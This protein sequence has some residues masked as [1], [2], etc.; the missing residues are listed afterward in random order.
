MKDAWTKFLCWF[1]GWDYKLLSECSAASTRTLR[2]YAD[3][4]LLIMAIWFYIGFSM[5]NR[6]FKIDN[7]CFNILVAFVF[8]LVVWIIERQIILIPGKHWGIMII[9]TLLAVI[10]AGLGATIIDQ[11][12]FGADIDAQKNYII[13]HETDSLYRERSQIIEDRLARNINV[14]DSLE[15]K[16]YTLN[17]ELST[18]QSISL[19]SSTFI[20]TDSMGRPN[21][22][23]NHQT[24]LNPKYNE[25]ER[26]N[27]LIENTKA[28][29]DSIYIEQQSLRDSTKVD[30][31]KSIGLLRE[32]EL[33]FSEK[34]V[35]KSGITKTF[36]FGL[37]AFFVLLELLVVTFKFVTKECDYEILVERQEAR[38]IKQIESIL[39]IEKDKG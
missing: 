21:Y 4:V 8:S 29:I 14:L 16:S 5:A 39:P 22:A 18:N 30:V 13:E 6:Y 26:V 3:A 2:R 38:K 37:L 15:K 10:M 1:I 11:A 28:T 17:N 20:S 7:L 35:F 32:L 25:L 27:R 33:T 24:V 19:R 9:R 12:F 36:Y 23:N 31:E 34:I